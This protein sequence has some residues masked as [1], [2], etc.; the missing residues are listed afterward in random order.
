MRNILE[1]EDTLS[2]VRHR[3][4]VA[5][6]DLENV[7][8]ARE[9]K[10]ARRERLG[11]EE[12]I[13][14]GVK[15]QIT[16][17]KEAIRVAATRSEELRLILEHNHNEQKTRR[18]HIIAMEH[19]LS[20]LREEERALA[21]QLQQFHFEQ[22]TIKRYHREY[23]EELREAGI[24]WDDIALPETTQISSTDTLPELKRQIDRTRIRLE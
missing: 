15:E 23:E 1:T 20:A 12:S 6:E 24:A 11:R 14:D 22:E 21:L 8:E 18:E 3:M 10:S 7:M 4:I 2:A 5:I 16:K 17:L 9:Q 19:H 13:W